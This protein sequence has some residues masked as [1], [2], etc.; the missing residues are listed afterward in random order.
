MEQ[1]I[2]GYYSADKTKNNFCVSEKSEII[3]CGR[4]QNFPPQPLNF[5]FYPVTF[6]DALGWLSGGKISVCFDKLAFQL[7]AK[8]FYKMAVKM[9]ANNSAE[10]EQMK[11]DE[12]ISIKLDF[13][14][15]QT[16]YQLN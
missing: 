4:T 14:K 16:N 5:E 10:L 7:Y 9:I 8:E 13:F 12:F 3:I 15:L 6:A 11:P 1:T 2:I